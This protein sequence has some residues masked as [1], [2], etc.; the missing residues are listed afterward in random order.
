MF[1]LICEQNKKVINLI[2]KQNLGLLNDTLSMIVK[3][4]P[5]ILDFENKRDYFKAELKKLKNHREFYSP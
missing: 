3:K 1:N 2:V 4:K 5:K